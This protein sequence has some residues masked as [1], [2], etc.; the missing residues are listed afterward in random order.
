MALPVLEIVKVLPAGV[1]PPETPL[2]EKVVGL[3]TMRGLLRVNVAVTFLSWVME[4]VQVPVPE[5]P[6]PD[7][8]VKV[9]P[10]KAEAVK[11]TDV[12]EV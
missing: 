5:H 8:P 12:P 3:R 7:Q 1:A 4:T 11:V 2:K 6:S 9:E 10:A